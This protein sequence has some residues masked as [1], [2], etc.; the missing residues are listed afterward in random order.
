M[1]GNDAK[2][3][4]W[5]CEE[6]QRAADVAEAEQISCKAQEAAIEAE[7]QVQNTAH[8]EEVRKNKG[9]YI[10]ILNWPPLSRL[11]EMVSEYAIRKMAKG[12]Y[13][14]M[15]YY[16]NPGIEEAKRNTG[17]MDNEAL[18]LSQNPDGSS[19][20]VPAGTIKQARAVIDD[21]HLKWEDFCQA[22]LR[23]VQAMETADWQPERVTMLAQ[24]WGNI[25]V[26][27]L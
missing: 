27:R 23:M 22:V 18:V 7:R 13:V 1:A 5:Q 21:E 25:M 4:I 14:K 20:L 12:A 10:P 11:P 2:K 15:W 19:S 8:T 26:H 16:T 6:A 3:V 9:K 17:T 24:L